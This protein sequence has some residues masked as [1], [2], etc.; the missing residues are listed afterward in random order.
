MKNRA[1]LLVALLGALLLVPLIAPATALAGTCPS[2][3]GGVLEKTTYR[4]G[5]RL[6][7]YGTYTD[8]AAA[9]TTTIDF[10]RPAD[11]ATRHEKASNLADGEWI[12]TVIFTSPSDVG[13]WNVRVVVTQNSGTSV[14]DDHFTLIHGIRRRH[15][16]RRPPSTSTVAVPRRPRPDPRPPSRSGSRASA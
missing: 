15:R 8:F 3:S 10:T 2:D 16:S 6:D 4:V 13:A 1:P 7:F 9:G 11:G 14:C 5:E 12:A